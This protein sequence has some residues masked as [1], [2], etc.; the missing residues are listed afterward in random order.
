M[1]I[2]GQGREGAGSRYKPGVLARVFQADWGLT[3]VRPQSQWQSWNA[4]C[5]LAGYFCFF[6]CLGDGVWKINAVGESLNTKRVR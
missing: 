4:V 6:V 2:Q 3:E 5:S 1:E